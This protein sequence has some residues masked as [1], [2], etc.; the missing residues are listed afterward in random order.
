MM[1]CFLGYYFS[2]IILF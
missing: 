2:E 1:V